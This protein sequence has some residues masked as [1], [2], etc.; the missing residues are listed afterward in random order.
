VE[1]SNAKG[2]KEIGKVM[3]VLAPQVK[4]KADGALVN[5]VVRELLG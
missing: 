4:G 2:E 3:A 5:K 1:Q